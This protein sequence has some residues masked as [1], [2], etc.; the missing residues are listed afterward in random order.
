[1]A[2][3][4]KYNFQLSDTFQNRMS[5]LISDSGL[6]RNEL[7]DYIGVSKDILIRAANVGMIPSTRSLIKI[8]DYFGL[9]IEFLIGLTDDDTF[10]KADP[11]ISFQERLKELKERSKTNF[12]EVADSIG[13]A[14]SLFRTWKT[15]DYIPTVEIMYN[16]AKYFNVSID[17]ILGRTDIENYKR[18]A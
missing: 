12:C 11:P 4:F 8:A 5:R 3:D 18:R 13:I 15:K 1:M 17:Y 6:H 2:D 10:S 9:S 7:K 14:R 16:L